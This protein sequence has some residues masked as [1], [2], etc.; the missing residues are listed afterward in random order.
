[1]RLAL[2]FQAVRAIFCKKIIP[3]GIHRGIFAVIRSICINAVYIALCAGLGVGEHLAGQ[4]RAGFAVTYS[5]P[6]LPVCRVMVWVSV[7]PSVKV[8]VTV[9]LRRQMVD[10][11]CHCLHIV[12]F[13]IPLAYQK[14]IAVGVVCFVKLFPA[15]TTPPHT[16]AFRPD[17][18]HYASEPFARG[19]VPSKKALT[20]SSPIAKLRIRYRPALS[21]DAL[22][23]WMFSPVTLKS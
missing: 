19:S 12:V 11:V 14:A 6:S 7:V 9:R 13:V 23:V 5:Q 15:S 10:P 4:L 22:T 3:D 8:T 21:I 1:M 16:S 2:I 17:C 18:R 20:S